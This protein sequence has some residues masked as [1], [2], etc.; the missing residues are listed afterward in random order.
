MPGTVMTL[1]QLSSLFANVSISSVTS[2]IRSSSCRQ[3]LARSAT[4][5]T[6]RGERTSVRLARMSGRP[7][8]RKRSPCRT[9]MP[10]LVVVLR[11]HL[12][13]RLPG[14]RGMAS[15]KAGD[16]I[17]ERHIDPAEF[18]ASALYGYPGQD[19]VWPGEF[20]LGYPASSPDPLVPG[21]PA[22]AEPSWTRNGSFLVFRRLRQDVGLFWRTMRDEPSSNPKCSCPGSSA[23]T[24]PS[25]VDT[26]M[27]TASMRARILAASSDVGARV[28]PATTIIASMGS[29]IPPTVQ[30]FGCH[31]ASGSVGS[32]SNADRAGRPS[33]NATLGI[34]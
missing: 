12:L 22:Q 21:P 2:S 11:V 33:L 10:L 16:Y 28:L 29:D 25:S 1:R 26:K 20:V 15:A 3:S 32:P 8:R 24:S 14:I 5:R 19:L 23:R 17:T 18:P 31:S 34:A 4:M 30:F 9:M 7:W 27:P 6:M 13:E